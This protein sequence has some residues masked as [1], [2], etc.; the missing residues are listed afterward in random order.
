M[1]AKIWLS[2]LAV[3]IA[4][5]GFAQEP[6]PKDKPAEPKKDE[7]KK[8]DTKATKGQLPANW[9][10]LGLTDKQTKAVYELQAKTNEKMDKLEAEIKSLKEKLKKDSLEVLTA[11]QKKRLEE[12][13]KEK[14]GTSEKPKP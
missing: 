12:I 13:L 6:K 2:L 3:T 7:V 1:P 4:S 14:S 10:L 5:S 8:D 9:K 11:E